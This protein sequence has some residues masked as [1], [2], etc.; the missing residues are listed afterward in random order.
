MNRLPADP[1]APFTLILNAS[2]HH[3][4]N[5]M[6]MARRLVA[7]LPGE[8]EFAHLYDLHIRP[9]RG[10]LRCRA[11]GACQQ[12]PGDDFLGVIAKLIRADALVFASPLHFTSLTAPLVAFISRLQAYWPGFR[13]DPGGMP[14]ARRR[15]ALL[16]C[17]GGNYPRMFEPAR[18]VAAAAFK[19][20]RIEF[21]GMVT[22]SGT[23]LLPP[24]S[25]PE[26]VAALASLAGKMR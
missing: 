9:C 22:A 10:C 21:T 26:V 6:A 19:T 17:G 16:L 15:G 13:A 2:P 5:A 8:A 12:G 14:P 25:Q 3:E 4:G 20:L 23:D 7:G 11:G 18:A 1:T 24:L